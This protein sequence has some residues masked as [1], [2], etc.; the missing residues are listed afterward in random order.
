MVQ[1]APRL[2]GLFL[3]AALV[4]TTA[5]GIPTG[6]IGPEDRGSAGQTPLSQALA[7]AANTSGIDMDYKTLHIGAT[8]CASWMRRDCFAIIVDGPQGLTLRWP[9]PGDP[10]HGTFVS[11]VLTPGTARVYSPDALAW[12]Q[13]MGGNG[14]A[15][16]ESLLPDRVTVE[17]W[18]GR[19]EPGDTCA[20]T[21]QGL[22]S[23]PGCAAPSPPPDSIPAPSSA[24]MLLLGLGVMF[25]FKKGTQ[26]RTAA[27]H[28][29]AAAGL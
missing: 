6:D 21:A 3:S 22:R 24:L 18:S 5:L 23:F 17:Q 7:A 29:A 9:D 15:W 25:M 28:T 8:I 27:D 13:I 12:G 11:Q 14:R 4:P 20:L 16:L 1:R 19:F 10:T 26:Y 2:A